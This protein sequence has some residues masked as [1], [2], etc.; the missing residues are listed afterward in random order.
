MIFFS[1]SMSRLAPSSG[2]RSQSGIATE[3]RIPPKRSNF[4]FQAPKPGKFERLTKIFV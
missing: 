3:S 4:G 2:Y 1:K